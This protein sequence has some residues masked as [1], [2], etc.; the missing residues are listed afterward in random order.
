VKRW[1]LNIDLMD[2]ENSTLSQTQI[3]PQCS[4][5]DAN[6][7]YFKEE[8]NRSGSDIYALVPTSTTWRGTCIYCGYY[9]VVEVFDVKTLKKRNLKGRRRAN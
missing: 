5:K 3:V 2:G 8:P 7:K 6:T 9:A 4:C 1:T